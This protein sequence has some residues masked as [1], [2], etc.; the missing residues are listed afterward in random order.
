MEEV[1]SKS[2]RT[3]N[4][5]ANVIRQQE[6][7]G[8][9]GRGKQVPHVRHRSQALHLSPNHSRN[10]RYVR[11]V[12]KRMQQGVQNIYVVTGSGARRAGLFSISIRLVSGPNQ[13][14]K[15]AR[16]AAVA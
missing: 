15:R 11:K 8:L 12:G 16:K 5:S 2:S 7:R 4:H 9:E 3:G 13:D 1:S 6:H 10:I 14:R